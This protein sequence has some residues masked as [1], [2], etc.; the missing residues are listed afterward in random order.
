MMSGPILRVLLFV[1]LAMF[2]ATVQA[3]STLAGTPFVAALKDGV[4]EGP[5][6]PMEMMPMATN[7]IQDKTGSKGDITVKAF[8]VMRFKS[9]PACGRVSFGLFQASTHT[10]WGQFG[11]QLN[12]CDDGTPPL[13]MCTGSSELVLPNRFCRDGSHPID[14]PEIAQAI[15]TA[16]KQGGVTPEQMKEKVRREISNK[17]AGA[18][19]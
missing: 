11:G 5:P 4:A 7:A 1:T 10:F 18:K 14:T 15:A 17:S 13:K 6:P 9:Q 12:V 16:V 3:Q 8:R 2:G 19:P